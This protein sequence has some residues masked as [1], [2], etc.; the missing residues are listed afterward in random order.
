MLQSFG[1]S[2]DRRPTRTRLGRIL[3]AG[4]LIAAVVVMTNASVSAG[5]RGNSAS[6]KQCVNWQELYKQDG[7][8]F[9]DRGECTSYAA[10]GG[11]ILTSPPPPPPDPTPNVVQVGSSPA[12]GNYPATGAEFGPAPTPVGVGGQLVLVN[13]GVGLSTD[14]CSPLV[15]FPAGAIAIV[16]R[17]ECEFVDQVANAQGAGASSVVVVNNAAGNPITLTGNAPHVSIASVMVSQADGTIIKAGLPA[18]GVVR[19]GI[20]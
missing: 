19:A 17:G 7:S 8:T 6:A 16:D 12:A 2:Q 4:G 5:P 18:T 11:I 13:D 15:G 1:V 14:G 10:S 3:A 9:F 20:A